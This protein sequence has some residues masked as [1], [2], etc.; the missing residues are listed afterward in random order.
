MSMKEFRDKS[1]SVLST[2]PRVGDAASAPAAA[3]PAVTSPGAA[4]LMQPMIDELKGRARAAEDRAQDLAQQLEQWDGAKAARLLDPNHIRPSRWAN[5]HDLSFSTPAF[6]A[7]KAEI[8]EAGSN[9]QP[10]K[11]RPLGEV[12]GVAQYELVYGHR[13]HR[14]CLELGLRVL[15]LIDTLDDAA[16]FVE[17]ERENRGRADLSPWEQGVMYRRALDSGLFPSQRRLAAAIG[18]QSGN[19]S[20]AVQLGSLPKEVVQAFPSPL[21]LQFRWAAPLTT[22]LE[23][24]PAG[25]LSRAREIMAET[26]RPSAKEVLARLLGSEEEAGPTATELKVAG[27]V[28]GGWEKDA[29]GNLT[30]RLKKGA[31]PPQDEKQLLEQVAR[32]FD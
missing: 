30:L 5:R 4:A 26:P 22:A 14:A 17:M 19:V 28:V 8:A 9:V 1:A 24:D 20:T 25:V 7:L 27:K 31:L 12:D 6:Q 21:D 15:A 10:I 29:R 3:R 16:L 2:L 13:R 23:K 18:A 32:F 11:V